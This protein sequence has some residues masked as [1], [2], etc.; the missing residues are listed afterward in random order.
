MNP[1]N[2]ATTSAPPGA[3]VS[4]ANDIL[5]LFTQIDIEHMQPMG[6]LL[7]NYAWM[8]TPAN[9]QNVYG[10]LTAHRMPPGGPYWTEAQLGL[11]NTWMT[12]GYNP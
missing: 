3:P 7:S 5:P 2:T 4:F 11:F 1:T 9:A 6:V 8:S 12:T 10:V